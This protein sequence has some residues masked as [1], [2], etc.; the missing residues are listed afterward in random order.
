MLAG[1]TGL[2]PFLSMLLWLKD[3]PTDQPITLAYGVNTTEDLVDRLGNPIPE[4]TSVVVVVEHD[5]GRR[6]FI[7]AVVTARRLTVSLLVPSHPDRILVSAVLLGRQ[8]DP[9]IIEFGVQ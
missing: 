8:S 5:D 1:G 6:D 7:P 9:L 4:G 2:A 3:N